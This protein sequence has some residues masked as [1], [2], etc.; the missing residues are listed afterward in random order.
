M[1]ILPALVSFVAAVGVG[2]PLM[3]VSDG[4]VGIIEPSAGVMAYLRASSGQ[5]A[6]IGGKGLPAG[7]G[8]VGDMCYS[9][10]FLQLATSMLY[11]TG[12]DV[13]ILTDAAP[14]QGGGAPLPSSHQLPHNIVE[15]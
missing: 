11:D 2:S 12:S 13:V 10:A 7:G 3:P 15:Y 1:R 8:R 9:A 14:V 6:P 5:V 4:T